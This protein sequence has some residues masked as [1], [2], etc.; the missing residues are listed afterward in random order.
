MELP[1]PSAL[2][3]LP[4]PGGYVSVAKVAVLLVLAVPWLYVAPWVYHDAR[5][6]RGQVAAWCLTVLGAGTVGLV[7]WI[8]IP[9]FV[10]GLLIYLFLTIAPLLAY[11]AYRN[12]RLPTGARVLSA[13]HL[14]SVFSSAKP[15]GIQP[16]TRL[17]LYNKDGRVQPEPDPQTAEPA[18]V[19]AYNLAQ[20]LLHDV[21]WRR[22]SEADLVPAGPQMRLRLVLDGVVN[23]TAPLEAHSGERVIQ[24]LK[25]IA[26][27]DPQERRRPQKGSLSVDLNQ[28]QI[29]IM[30]TTTGTTSGQRMRLRV[31]QQ[32]VRQD[33]D[34]LGMSGEVLE[35]VR[36]LARRPG[37]LLV[38]GP[39]RSGVTS[40]LYSLLRDQD[41]YIK[42]IVTVEQRVDLDLENVTQHPCERD[43]EFADTLAPVL[44]LDPDVVMV[45][46]CPD[47]AGAELITEAAGEKTFF[48]GMVARDAFSAL[49][50][51]VRRRGDAPAAVEHLSGVLCQILLRKLCPQCREPYRPDRQLLAKAN[52]PVDRIRNF[53]RPPVRPPTDEKGQAIVCSQCQ[54]TG[55]YERTA[56]FELLVI[57]D[58]IR[59]LVTSGAT[60]RDIK[61][62]ARKTKMLYLQEEALRKVIAGET[63]VQEVLRVSQQGKKT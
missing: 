8:A 46:R 57:T 32:A 3:Q 11:V 5:R 44:R 15:R 2:A 13:E 7:L 42:Q 51:W 6:V 63:S 10:V 23:D 53:Y 54:G 61:A 30:V 31:V 17:K 43:E 47:A 9:V 60:L 20:N 40:T 34:Q 52:L 38:S 4:E 59:R 16:V 12:A 28:Q 27:L 33:L 45:A 58:E 18:E 55:Y 41:A 24:Y 35:R 62:A 36:D 14:R 39:P 26:G 29:D 1:M 19:E 25:P 22:A 21:L 50:K 37:I 49:A 56:A 48:V